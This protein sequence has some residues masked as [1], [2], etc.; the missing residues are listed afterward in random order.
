VSTIDPQITGRAPR[1]SASAE[2]PAFEPRGSPTVAFT[3]AEFCFAH[4]ISQAFYYELKR[5]G[6]GPKEMALGRRRIISGE[7]AADWRRA[8]AADSA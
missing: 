3:V 6:L 7:A 5:A 2:I 1:A 4:K 8:R